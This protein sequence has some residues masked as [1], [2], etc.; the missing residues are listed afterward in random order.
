VAT[1]AYLAITKTV[2]LIRRPRFLSAALPYFL[3]SCSLFG[4]VVSEWYGLCYDPEK[5]SFFFRFRAVDLYSGSSPAAPLVLLSLLFFCF[6]LFQL[7]RYTL[8]GPGRPRLDFT[9]R[10]H[11][12]H[13]AFALDRELRE[14]CDGVNS[15]IMPVSSNLSDGFT[16]AA[17]G[18]IFVLICFG[19]LGF[20]PSAFELRPY[21]QALLAVV[22]AALFCLAIGC[23]NLVSI[24]RSLDRL[25]SH[26]EVELLPLQPSIVRVVKE[27]PRRAIRVFGPAVSQHA[28]TGQMWQ[29]LHRR[30]VILQAREHN[31]LKAYATV[32]LG[33][34]GEAPPQFSLNRNLAEEPMATTLPEAQND[35]KKFSE[36]AWADRAWHHR[37]TPSRSARS[38][39]KSAPN[40]PPGFT[41]R[42]WRLAWRNSLNEDE[43]PRGLA[44]V[45]GSR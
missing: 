34:P 33:I 2:A 14:A 37:K 17:V 26:V 38:T 22:P 45:S 30:V 24:S 42:T 35:L 13:D 11:G 41:R 44:G 9:L 28:L 19:F 15:Q 43:R 32:A 20:S 12:A 5:S 18:L 10:A 36:V 1:F 40:W 4:F 7:K 6:A 23:Y 3:L 25:L 21:N 8:A 27:W 31:D 29:A 16:R 39:R